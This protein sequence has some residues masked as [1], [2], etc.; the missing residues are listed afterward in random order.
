MADVR[1]TFAYFK[2][3]APVKRVHLEALDFKPILTGP[4]IASWASTISDG[5][6]VVHGGMLF[7]LKTGPPGNRVSTTPSTRRFCRLRRRELIAGTGHG[8]TQVEKPWPTEL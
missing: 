8:L 6:I 7:A 4:A 1:G 3:L 2:A 5:H